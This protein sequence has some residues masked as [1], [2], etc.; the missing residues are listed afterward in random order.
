VHS[1][2]NGKDFGADHFRRTVNNTTTTITGMDKGFGLGFERENGSEEFVLPKQG[3]TQHTT[4]RVDY[5]DEADAEKGRGGASSSG[6]SSEI[7][8]TEEQV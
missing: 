4:V 2:H 1:E 6:N 3:I 5:E 7:K 8:R